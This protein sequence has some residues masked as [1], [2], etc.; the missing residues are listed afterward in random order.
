MSFSSISA[1]PKSRMGVLVS[2]PWLM[3]KD[4]IYLFSSVA[5]CQVKSTTNVPQNLQVITF[6]LKASCG[7]QCY[8]FVTAV[9]ETLLSGLL[10]IENTHL[11]SA[12][13]FPA[14]SASRYPSPGDFASLDP[15][16]PRHHQTKK[17]HLFSIFPLLS[18]PPHVF[19]LE[20]LSMWTRRLYSIGRPYVCDRF[21][22]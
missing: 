15:L 9:R 5:P 14:E 22:A 18:D 17:L 12:R 10:S 13:F 19:I 21:D 11:Y 1:S 6:G 7:R 16:Y 20:K 2:S 3:T 4:R 8:R